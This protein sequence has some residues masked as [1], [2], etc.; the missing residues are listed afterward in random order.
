MMQSNFVREARTRP[1]HRHIGAV[2][3]AAALLGGPVF[4]CRPGS[5]AAAGQSEKPAASQSQ[6]STTQND[7]TDLAVTVYNSNVALVR[8]VRELTLPTGAFRL[9]F[10]DIAATI[11]PTTVHFRSL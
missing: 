11:N 1:I 5:A 3:L 2:L 9:R 10:M 4:V 6:P 7:Q 8:D